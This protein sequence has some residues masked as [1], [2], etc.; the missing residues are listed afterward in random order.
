MGISGKL[1]NCYGCRILQNFSNSIIFVQ[2]WRLKV[3]LH[4]EI[5]SCNMLLGHPR[6]IG[7]QKTVLKDIKNSFEDWDAKKLYNFK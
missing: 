6:G 5:V 2:P 3:V 4:I 1:F 7:W